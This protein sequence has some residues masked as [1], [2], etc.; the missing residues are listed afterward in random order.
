MFTRPSS[1]QLPVKLAIFSWAVVDDDRV[2]LTDILIGACLI[3]VLRKLKEEDRF[4]TE[5]FPN[6]ETVIKTAAEWEVG[7]SVRNTKY[8]IVF[9]C[10]K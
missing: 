4:N 1:L 3:A 9:R 2:M 5:I 10:I 7:G 6:L 8:Q